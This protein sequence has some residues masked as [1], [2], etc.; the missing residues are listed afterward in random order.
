MVFAKIS[1]KG[2]RVV[3]KFEGNPIDAADCMSYMGD[4]EEIYSRKE[5]FLIM[6]DAR[7][8]GLLR[9]DYINMQAA[10]MKKKEKETKEYMVRA[11]IIV[12][13]TLA[14]TM[15]SILFKIQTPATT[16]GVFTTISE[17]K[18]FLNEA[19]LPHIHRDVDSEPAT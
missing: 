2:N 14:K 15:L 9:W 5:K 1:Q 18:A 8:I 6:Y 10:F 16:Y 11:A 4:L 17:A 7:E 3:V 19:D 12:G 13:S